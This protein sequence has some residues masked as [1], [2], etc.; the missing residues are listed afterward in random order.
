MR[1]V[2]HGGRQ[3]LSLA[4][5]AYPSKSRNQ[6]IK[7]YYLNCGC[8][9]LKPSMVRNVDPRVTLV[10]L[11][12]GWSGRDFD[13]HESARPPRRAGTRNAP[14][15]ADRPPAPRRKAGSD[16]DAASEPKRPATHA[17]AATFGADSAGKID[18]RPFA[19]ASNR[20]AGRRRF[21][22]RDRAT[23]RGPSSHFDAE[24]DSPHKR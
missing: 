18:L 9:H 6:T 12:G 1:G 17:D 4:M 11:S 24:V 3:F 5:S 13:R 23:E 2:G 21:L 10:S 7:R 19:S 22:A 20:A 15:G 8:N 16:G 14:E